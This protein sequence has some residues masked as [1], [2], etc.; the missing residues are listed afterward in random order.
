MGQRSKYGFFTTVPTAKKNP[1]ISECLNLP[2]V[3]GEQRVINKQPQMSTF[4]SRCYS[5]NSGEL[6]FSS[7]CTSTNDEI[8]RV[9]EHRIVMWRDLYKSL[10]AVSSFHK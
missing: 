7:D 2:L 10:N 3:L 9:T 5:V 8:I 4:M 6:I 1:V